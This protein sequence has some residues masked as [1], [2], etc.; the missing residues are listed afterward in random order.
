MVAFIVITLLRGATRLGHGDRA[1]SGAAGSGVSAAH[2][3]GCPPNV[4]GGL[5]QAHDL[6]IP[7]VRRGRGLASYA[8]LM[9]EVVGESSLPAV[10][11]MRAVSPHRASGN[12]STFHS[13]PNS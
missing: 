5:S 11:R 10:L 6:P 7:G 8:L 9:R 3:G 4:S 13:R 1:A 2:C 12:S